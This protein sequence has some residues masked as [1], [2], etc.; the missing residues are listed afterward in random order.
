MTTHPSFLKIEL[1]LP[2]GKAIVLNGI[3]VQPLSCH[4]LTVNLDTVGSTQDEIVA[5]VEGYAKGKGGFVK[6]IAP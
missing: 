5:K 3:S 2:E 1:M 4:S 6:V